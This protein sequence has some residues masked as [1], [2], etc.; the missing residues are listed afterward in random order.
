MLPLSL[1]RVCRSSWFLGR[2]G[3]LAI[4]TVAMSL[5]LVGCGGGG[6]GSGDSKSAV[7]SGGSQ[8]AAQAV[9]KPESDVEAHRFLVQATFGPRAE[10]IA[11]VRDVGYAQWIDEQF[12]SPVMS[13]HLAVVDTSAALRGRVAGSAELIYSWWTHAIQDHSAQLR[14]K[15]AYALSQIFVVSSI[16]FDDTRTVASYLDML[17]ARSDGSYRDLLEAVALHPAMGQY[18]SHLG[19]RKEDGHGRVPDENFAREVMQLFSIG[20]YELDDAGNPKMVNGQHVETYS[21]EDIKGLARVFT[22]FSWEW[23]SAKSALE[24]WKCFWRATE[25]KVASQRVTAMTAYGSEHS[26]VQK[27][28]LGVT[29]P[30]QSSAAPRA[31]LK[32]ALDR[33]ANHPNTAPFISRQLIQRLVTSN[34]SNQYVTDVT[35][36]FRATGGNLKAVVKEILLHPEA[37]RTASAQ[38]PANTFGKVR[39]PILRLAHLMRVVPHTSAQYAGNASSGFYLLTDTSDPGTQLGQSPMRAPS[40]FNFYRPGYRPPQTLVAD[41]G[42]VA[43]EM[44]ITTETSVLGYANFVAQILSGGWGEWN[45]TLSRPDV[46]FDFN[47]WT[48]EAS[49]ASSLIDAVSTRLLGQ[50]LAEPVRAQA[51][52]ALETLPGNSAYQKRQRVQAAILLVA[53]SPDFSV[54]H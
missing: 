14:H 23:P 16:P 48:A 6:G 12:A 30:A 47:P 38:S 54:Q 21:S 22:G 40:V 35:R 34:P 45:A 27:A 41:Q 18:L 46:L 44:Q 49:N 39:E 3:T 19:N 1:S 31:S 5:G 52:A 28:F 24:W 42:L 15:T 50:A 2:A 29:V 33:L 36:T 13:S 43:P 8:A 51:I 26:L 7:G 10:D 11:R 20:L 32:V 25:C 53:V 9:A 37:R 4:A 17:T